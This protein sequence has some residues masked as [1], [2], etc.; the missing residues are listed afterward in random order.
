M[1]SPGMFDTY[2]I[3][4]IIKI[5]NSIELFA[6]ASIKCVNMRRYSPYN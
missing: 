4:R 6:G 5:S 2:E 3:D 1:I